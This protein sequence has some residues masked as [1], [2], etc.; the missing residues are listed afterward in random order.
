MNLDVRAYR[1]NIPLCFAYLCWIKKDQ[2]QI[3]DY[4]RSNFGYYGGIPTPP[5]YSTH[6]S[7]RLTE[8]QHKQYYNKI[9]NPTNNYESYTEYTLDL[10]ED[11]KKLLEL[12]KYIIE[13]NFLKNIKDSLDLIQKDISELKPV[14][15]FG[16][17]SQ[18]KQEAEKSFNKSQES[19]EEI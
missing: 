18:T 19:L 13:S 17:N 4:C 5:I 9:L 7:L 15:M 10:T 14:L 11:I 16:P 3:E 6:I 2:K 12:N 8:I 1:D